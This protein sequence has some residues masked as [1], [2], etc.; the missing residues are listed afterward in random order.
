METFSSLINDQGERKVNLMKKKTKWNDK[1]AFCS[2]PEEEALA[3]ISLIKIDFSHFMTNDLRVW[4]HDAS[5][6][7]PIELNDTRAEITARIRSRRRRW[8]TN[9]FDFRID[10]KCFILWGALKRKM[11]NPIELNPFHIHCQ[12]FETSKLFLQIAM[13]WRVEMEFIRSFAFPSYIVCQS[14]NCKIGGNGNK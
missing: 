10:L 8:E 5:L 2:R 6:R 14:D 11:P 4:W 3:R 9:K 12:Y 7:I 1:L 13:E